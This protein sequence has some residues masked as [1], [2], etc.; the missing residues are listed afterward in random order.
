MKLLIIAVGLRFLN[1]RLKN[2][3]IVQKSYLRKEV[4]PE[5]ICT[6][7]HGFFGVVIIRI[8]YLLKAVF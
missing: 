5:I 7:V 6:L 1:Y 2:F 4:L 3:F 8:Y